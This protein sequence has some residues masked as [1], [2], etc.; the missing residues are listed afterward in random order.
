M[1]LLDV[2]LRQKLCVGFCTRIVRNVHCSHSCMLRTDMW[3]YTKHPFLFFSPTL[4]VSHCCTGPIF[5]QT[6]LTGKFSWSHLPHPL[7]VQSLLVTCEHQQCVCDL[8]FLW[9][10]WVLSCQSCS[11]HVVSRVLS[12]WYSYGLLWIYR[13]FLSS[14]QPCMSTHESVCV[15]MCV[16]ICV[17]DPHHEG[18]RRFP[19]SALPLMCPSAPQS[20]RVSLPEEANLQL[21]GACRE[22]PTELKCSLC[23]L[24]PPFLAI[25]SKNVFPP[26]QIFIP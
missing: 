17:C 26:L 18:T 12:G 7:T 13:V 6:L 15:C 10:T 14:M 4:T 3:G 5:A 22:V 24:H 2:N 21:N 19:H 9:Y 20:S 1:W 16:C 8:V 25:C 23:L 11:Q